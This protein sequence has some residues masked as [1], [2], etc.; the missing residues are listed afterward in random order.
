MMNDAYQYNNNVISKT[1]TN[2]QQVD[3]SIRNYTGFKYSTYSPFNVRLKTSII[4]IQYPLINFP[5]IINSVEI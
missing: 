2:T 1:S 4:R 3:S 5:I